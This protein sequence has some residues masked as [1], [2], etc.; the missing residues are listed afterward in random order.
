MHDLFM[1]AGPFKPV[2]FKP[3]LPDAESIPIPI[4]DFQNRS[5]PVAENKQVTGKNVQLICS[6]AI[7]E[8]PL[9]DFRM[10]V[11]PRAK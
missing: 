11:A 1:G 10:S 4:Q 6:L 9:M 3:F 5:A 8:R 2:F 7:M